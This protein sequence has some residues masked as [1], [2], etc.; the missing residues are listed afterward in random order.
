MS[1]PI[2]DGGT[3]QAQPQN[4]YMVMMREANSP[5]TKNRNLRDWFAGLAL[6][7]IISKAPHESVPTGVDESDLARARGAYDYADAMLKVRK[8]ES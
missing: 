8:G 1:T 4:E 7:A 2:D 5:E 3:A 6:Q